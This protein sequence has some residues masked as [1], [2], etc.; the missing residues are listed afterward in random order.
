[1]VETRIY[2][3]SA[4]SG[5]PIYKPCHHVT[6]IAQAGATTSG[7]PAAEHIRLVSSLVF[8]I[9]SWACC[10][11]SGL[12][13]TPSLGSTNIPTL[14][15]AKVFLGDSHLSFAPNTVARVALTGLIPHSDSRVISHGQ[16]ARLVPDS[17]SSFPCRSRTSRDCVLTSCLQDIFTSGYKRKSKKEMSAKSIPPPLIFRNLLLGYLDLI[18]IALSSPF[19]WLLRTCGN[20][21]CQI[22]EK[23]LTRRFFV[24]QSQSFSHHILGWDAVH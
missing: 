2:P 16:S 14:I 4:F 3:H 15:V 19:I 23:I 9:S 7:R 1:M 6:S 5:P 20:T 21:R 22:K 13:Q 8:G 24:S 12:G 11:S 18:P 10:Q 17:L